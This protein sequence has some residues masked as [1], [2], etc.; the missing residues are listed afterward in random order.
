MEIGVRLRRPRAGRDERRG[1][2]G[3]G[4]DVE[5]RRVDVEGA[6]FDGHFPNVT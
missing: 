1:L 5:V 6:D 3:I 2:S 4:G